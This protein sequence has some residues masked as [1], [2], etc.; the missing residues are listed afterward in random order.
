MQ[1]L[2]KLSYPSRG[3]PRKRSHITLEADLSKLLMEI[4]NTDVSSMRNGL[5]EREDAL[6]SIVEKLSIAKAA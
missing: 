6:R 5:K 2:S 3:W 4:A 1:N